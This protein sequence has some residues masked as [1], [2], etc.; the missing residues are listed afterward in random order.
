[1]ARRLPGRPQGSA[2][3][4]PAGSFQRIWDC[5]KLNCLLHSF[6]SPTVEFS[7]VVITD[8]GMVCEG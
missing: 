7:A 8:A 6:F 4:W 3:S 5:Q 2:V 1:M